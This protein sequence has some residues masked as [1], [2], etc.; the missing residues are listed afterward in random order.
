MYRIIQNSIVILAMI[1]LKEVGEDTKTPQTT[2]ILTPDGWVIYA[3]AYEDG[4]YIGSIPWGA[5][6]V[7]G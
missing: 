1:F 5:S 7:D 4:E 3:R 2:E 6:I